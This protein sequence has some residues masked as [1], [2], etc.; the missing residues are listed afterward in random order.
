M[1]E[2]S[3]L[4]LFRFSLMRSDW[5]IDRSIDRST[6][7]LIESFSNHSFACSS[8]PSLIDL[9]DRMPNWL[10]FKQTERS[11][12][13]F[14]WRKRISSSLLWVNFWVLHRFWEHHRRTN[15]SLEAFLKLG[16]QNDKDSLSGWRQDWS[17]DYW[18]SWY[19]DS[20]CWKRNG[21][22]R[23]KIWEDA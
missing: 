18:S 5:M 19:L 7:W 8:I 21:E 13:N 22:E 14:N 16:F 2:A 6:D 4:R 20:R 17:A 12:R 15:V 1:E 23:E 10:I 3:T 9:P 11:R